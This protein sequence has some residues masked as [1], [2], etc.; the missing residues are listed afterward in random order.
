[1][2]DAAPG[3]ERPDQ[4]RTRKRVIG[5]IGGV[6][7][8]IAAVVVVLVAAGGGDSGTSKRASTA[9]VTVLR[10][11]K[12][13]LPLG[14]VSADSAGPAVTVSPELS[15]QVLTVVGN[16]VKGA[17]VEPLRSG[18]PSKAN[19]GT[20]FDA[21]TLAQATGIDRGIVLDEG[22]PKVTGTLDVLAQP[23]ALVGL[24]DQGGNLS[25]VTAAVV[26]D[27][28]GQTAVKTSPLHIVR[29]ADFVL[30]PDGTGAWKVTAYN[31]V[32]TR[33]GGGLDPTT[34]TTT[35]GAVK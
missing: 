10:G 21:R 16:Y 12:I 26:L 17:T 13:S 9:P 31:M 3:T 15:Q 30:A 6:A 2:D 4:M 35:V 34:T 11:D 19:L 8:A 5:I 29:R 24:G 32:V 18:A 20:V 28:N 25:L 33:A 7:V 23:I 27:V 1:M 14:D 22:L